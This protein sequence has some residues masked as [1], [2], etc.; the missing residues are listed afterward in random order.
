MSL[1]L[2]GTIT[3]LF[4]QP[5]PR[6]P[7]ADVTGPPET[8]I[9]SRLEYATANL[10]SK[11]YRAAL[12][13]SE[14]VL[15]LAPNRADAVR[16]RDEA[17]AMLARFDQAV[18]KATALLAAG[19]ADGASAAIDAARAIDPAAPAVSELSARLVN[20]VKSRASVARTRSPA[21]SPPARVTPAPPQA[22]NDAAGR[23]RQETAVPADLPSSTPPPAA[24]TPLPQAEVLLRQRRRPLRPG[25]AGR[26]GYASGVGRASRPRPNRRRRFSNRWPRQRLRPRVVRRQPRRRGTTTT[27]RPSAAWSPRMCAPSKRRI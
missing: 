3:Y 1:V 12:S 24:Q 13:Q 20:Q 4:W 23:E 19:D 26:A 2:A 17:T 5:A 6:T 10:Q 8:L 15:R 9:Q 16:V 27:T 25:G 11:N 18:A 7:F 22:S 21:Q 14:E